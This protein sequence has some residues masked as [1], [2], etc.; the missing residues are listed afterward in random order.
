MRL[1]KTDN[2]CRLFSLIPFLRGK[3]VTGTSWKKEASSKRPTSISKLLEQRLKKL[4]DEDHLFTDNSLTVK[5]LAS[6]MGVSRATM[7]GVVTS[8]FGMGFRDYVNRRR[9]GYAKEYMLVHPEATQDEIADVCGFKDGNLFNR[10]FK[11]I[12]GETPLSWLART[13]S[14]QE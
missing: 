13:L 12:E 3:S 9:I 14:S 11:S 10:K 2:M 4:M 1:V 5:S 7:T 6:M 8:A